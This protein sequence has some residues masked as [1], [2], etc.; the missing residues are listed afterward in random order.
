[1]PSL[2]VVEAQNEKLLRKKWLGSISGH[3]YHA[4]GVPR[5]NMTKQ[6]VFP[7]T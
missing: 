2:V 4:S 1:M 6:R 5:H 7:T 3:H